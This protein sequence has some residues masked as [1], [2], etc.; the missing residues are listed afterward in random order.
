MAE[1]ALV[2]GGSSGIGLAIVR[3]LEADGFEVRAVRPP[4]VPPGTSRLR[5]VVH[6]DHSPA[7]VKRLAQAVLAAAN[8]VPA[9]PQVRSTQVRPRPAP[10]A[11]HTAAPPARPSS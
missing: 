8:A 4:T 2:T 1:T 9:E 3:A 10:P 11:P 6:A 7:D 5:L